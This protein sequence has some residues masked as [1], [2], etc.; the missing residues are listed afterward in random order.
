[1]ADELDEETQ[2]VKSSMRTSGRAS[3]AEGAL[4][5]TKSWESKVLVDRRQGRDGG[6]KGGVARVRM[7]GGDVGAGGRGIAAGL[8]GEDARVSR[9]LSAALARGELLDL[10]Q[11][12]KPEQLLP[13]LQVFPDEAEREAVGGKVFDYLAAHRPLPNVGALAR[14]RSAPRV[15]CCRSQIEARVRGPHAGRISTAVPDLDRALSGRFPRGV[16]DLAL[17]RV[18]RRFRDS[19][20]DSSDHRHGPDSGGELARSA[21]RYA[22]VQQIR[23][24]RGAGMRGVVVAVAARFEL[25]ALL[26]LVLHAAVRGAGAV[27]VADAIRLGARRERREGESGSVPAGGSD[28]DP[29]GVFPGGLLRAQLGAVARSAR[30]AAG[31]ALAALDRTAAALARAAGDVRG[32]AGAGAFSFC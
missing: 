16:S 20:R 12:S 9:R 17:E 5:V 2:A 13:F 28:Q 23:M 19:A 18:S 30:E 11:V 1:M 8:F 27:R 4:A 29:A 26:G 7:A 6:W 31:S 14:L 22:R 21:A 32:G 3:H 10:N 24:G 25:P 15:P